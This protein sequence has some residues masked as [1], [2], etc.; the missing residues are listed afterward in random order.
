MAQTSTTILSSKSH[1]VDITV[2]EGASFTAST[3]T[4]ATTSTSLSALL[5]FDVVSITGTTYNNQSF[6]VKSVADDGLS[7]VVYETVTLES[8]DGSTDTVIDHVGFVSD[9]QKGDGYYSKPDGL[10]TV[11]YH[12]DASLNDDENISIKMQGSLAT[13]PTEDDWFDIS[14]TSIGQDNID[15]S[16]LAFSSNFTGNFVWV[17]AKVSG[18]SAGSITSILL[19]N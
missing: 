14:G 13:T 1:K 8:S 18:M 5:P 3:G 12:I 2:T 19:N 7:M 15:G 6:T 11:A 17:R 16:T 4:I 9:K 10:H